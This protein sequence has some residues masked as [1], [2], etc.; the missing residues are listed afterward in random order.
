MPTLQLR[1]TS[2]F[3]FQGAWELGQ[4]FGGE[5]LCFCLLLL[6]LFFSTSK[7]GDYFVFFLKSQNWVGEVFFVLVFCFFGFVLYCFVLFF[8]QN[9]QFPHHNLGSGWFFFFFFL[10]RRFFAFFYICLFVCFFLSL[11]YFI[12]FYFILFCFFSVFFV[13]ASKNSTP[14]LVS[15]SAPL[16]LFYYTDDGGHNVI[17][18]FELPCNSVK[19]L[20]P[21]WNFTNSRM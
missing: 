13:F 2:L 6:L 9:V 11:F 3:W 15:N 8:L 21:I 16:S 14:P 1:R 12:L 7:V 4:V 19:N 17:D 20:I 10:S 18:N 5:L